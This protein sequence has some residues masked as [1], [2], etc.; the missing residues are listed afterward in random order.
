[1]SNSLRKCRG[2]GLEAWTEEDLKQFVPRTA[3]KYNRDNECINCRRERLKKERKIR[4]LKN[5]EK[6]RLIITYSNMKQRCNNPNRPEYKFYGARGI[7]ICEEW[8]NNSKGF[9]S[10]ALTNGFKP[11]LTLDRIDNDGPYSP[12][13]CRWVDGIQQARNRRNNTTNLDKK[14][15]ICG[16]CKRELP[17]SEFHKD[18]NDWYGIKRR[19]K[20]CRSKMNKIYRQHH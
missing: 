4:K 15:R 13:N 18:S 12:E 9:I 8:N 1:M 10:W 14:T 2:C 16:L 20:E 3:S 6:H 5:P 17:F 11:E 7:T 19:C